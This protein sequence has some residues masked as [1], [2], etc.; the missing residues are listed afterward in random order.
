MILFNTHSHR[1]TKVKIS[2]LSWLLCLLLSLT[3][4]TG[5]AQVVIGQDPP[6]VII[7][8]AQWGMVDKYILAFPAYP[9]NQYAGFIGLRIEAGLD[10][11][12]DHAF[13]ATTA[14]TTAQQ[15][16]VT[17]SSTGGGGL[18]P[19]NFKANLSI[20]QSQP[21][22]WRLLDVSRFFGSNG[23]SN[24]ITVRVSVP[25][26]PT[27][28]GTDP[29]T[30]RIVV[31]C[32]PEYS[33][34]GKNLSVVPTALTPVAGYEQTLSWTNACPLVKN[35]QLQLL[36]RPT[37]VSRTNSQLTSTN[38]GYL[39]TAIP[40]ETEWAQQGTLIET[41]SSNLFYK[42]T[43]AEGEGTYHWRVRALGNQAGGVANPDNWS[44]WSTKDVS[45]SVTAPDA[46]SNWIYSRSFSESGHVAEKLT[47]A[48][49]LQQV[50]QI[51]TRLA[52]P[53][54]STTSLGQQIVATQTLQ[55]FVGRDAVVSLPIP[56]QDANAS[57]LG[58]R[59]A[60]LARTAGVPYEA[61]HFDQTSNTPTDNTAR[62]PLP[63]LEQGYYSS[64][65][66]RVADAEGYPFTRTLF[67]NDGTNR[68][69]EQ[70][71][72]GT[73]LRVRPTETH[74]V[75]TSY[76]S[77]APEEV[78]RLFGREAPQAEGLYKVITTDPNNTS[79]VSYQT[80][81]GKTIATALAGG[82][83]NAALQNLPSAGNTTTVTESITG[84]GQIIS[85]TITL[86]EAVSLTGSY[87]ITPSQ[88]QSTCANYCSTCDYQVLIRIVNVDAEPGSDIILS[89]STIVKASEQCSVGSITLINGG[90]VLSAGTYRIERELVPVDY[91]PVASGVPTVGPSTTTRTL[92]QHLALL[93]DALKTKFAGAAGEP[94]TNISGFLDPATSDVDGL[95]TYLDSKNYGQENHDGQLCYKIPVPGCDEY[96]YFPRLTNY[97]PAPINLT[98]PSFEAQLTDALTALNQQYTK[99]YSAADLLSPFG[100]NA[101]QF[102]QLV[103]NMAA[104][105]KPG[106]STLIYNPSQLQD[107]WQSLLA[108][109]ESLLYQNYG[110]VGN[111]QFNLAKEYLQCAGLNLTTPVSDPTKYDV[112]R[113]FE[114]F[115]YNDQNP[116][117]VNCIRMVGADNTV[118]PPSIPLLSYVLAHFS[119][120]DQAKRNQVYDCLQYVN[121]P[122]TTTGPIPQMTQAEA[123]AQAAMLTQQ[124]QQTCEDRRDEFRRVL[125]MQ[126]H[127]QG[128]YIEGDTY[129]WNPGPGITGPPTISQ[130]LLPSNT[131][132][133]PTCV[134]ESLV[135][136]L[137]E[138][139]QGDAHL[140]AVATND[141]TTN[142]TYYQVGTAA[143][144]ESVK[145]AM[146]SSL[147]VYVNATGSCP[148]NSP[149]PALPW[150]PVTKNS[151]AGAPNGAPS[152]TPH[153]SVTSTG[154][155]ILSAIQTLTAGANRALAQTTPRILVGCTGQLDALNEKQ[156]NLFSLTTILDGW[157]FGKQ[158]VIPGDPGTY[159]T[160]LDARQARPG[161][162]N[163]F[164][165][166]WDYL[167]ITARGD[168][169]NA[170]C[171]PKTTV[172]VNS[173]G[174]DIL[175]DVAETAG[176]HYLIRFVDP[177]SEQPFEKAT[178]RSISAPYIKFFP[179][180]T[181][182]GSL[183]TQSNSFG[184]TVR[185][186]LQDPVTQKLTWTEANVR[187]LNDVTCS[188]CLP[189]YNG[190]N[191]V[192]W[193]QIDTQCI[194][195]TTQA[196]C[197]QWS[198]VPD[199]VIIPP[200]NFPIYDPQ[201]EACNVL[202]ARKLR[203]AYAVEQ[204]RWISSQ[205][206]AFSNQFQQQCVALATQQENFT[207]TYQL[208][209]HHFTLYY[210]DRAGNLLKT[211]PP[212]GVVPLSSA[213]VASCMSTTDRS[214][215]P[216]PNH[217]LSTTYLYNSLHQLEKQNSPDGGETHFFYNRKGQLRFS[218]N[219][220][221]RTA[222]LPSYSYTRY[223]A[224]GRVTEVGETFTDATGNV[225]VPEE[226]KMPQSKAEDM[227]YPPFD[228]VR[229]VT[230]TFYGDLNSSIS[231]L[232]KPQRYLTNRVA[233]SSYDVDGNPAIDDRSYTYYSYDPHGNV[234][235]L[236]QEQP[237]LGRKF[238]RYEYDLISNKVTKV[239]YQENQ[240]D[241]FYHRYDY[242][243]DN[244]LT[245][246][247]TSG[248][249]MI[250]D[251]DARYT[252]FAHGPLKRLEI[253]EDH[254]Q[255]IDY[256][257]TLQGWLKGLN[258]PTN[259]PGQ[260]G[261]T[262][263]LTASAKD[264]F[265][266]ALG[267]F[268]GDYA[269]NNTA[270][271]SGASSLLQPQYNLYNGNIA[272]WTTKTRN[273]LT[274]SG[275]TT[276]TDP[277]VGEQYRYDQLNRITSSKFFRAATAGG[278]MQATDDYAT[279]YT[280]DANGN[281]LT[282]NRNGTSNA[283][284]QL[285]MDALSYSYY[286]GT[287]RLQGI[288]DSAP[289][290]NYYDDIKLDPNTASN[291]TYDNIGNL[292]YETRTYAKGN[293][294]TS[295]D[296]NIYGK[297][298]DSRSGYATHYDYDPQGN[299]IHKDYSLS[300][301][302]DRDRVHHVYYVRD[303][304][305]NVL[306]VYEWDESGSGRYKNS[307]LALTE[308]H[309]YGSSRLGIR[310]LAAGTAPKSAPTEYFQRIVGQ[311]QY[312]LMDHLGNVRA[313]VSDIKRPD[314]AVAG[315]YKPDL[316]AYYGYYPFGQLQPGRNAPANGTLAGGYRYGY[317]GK[318]KDSNG[319]LGLTTYD[320][321]FRIYNPGLGKFLSVDPL[322]RSYPMLTP[323]QF[324]SNRPI[325]MVDL[326]GLEAVG[327][328]P[329]VGPTIVPLPLGTGQSP[330]G[331]YGAWVRN[332]TKVRQNDPHRVQ[333]TDITG[334][335]FDEPLE[336]AAYKTTFGYL[337]SYG[338][339][340]KNTI[341]YTDDP[342]TLSDDYL[343]TV[344]QRSESGEELSAQERSYLNEAYSRHNSRVGITKATITTIAKKFDNFQ[345]D[346]CAAA[347][348]KE[349]KKKGISAEI[350]ELKTAAFNKGGEYI[351]ND[352]VQGTISTNG[353]H[354]G[355]LYEGK[356]YDNIYPEGIEYKD[357]QQ[358]FDA[359]SHKLNFSKRP[360]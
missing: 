189:D 19:S 219:A 74:T 12:P 127:Q 151:N 262:T 326:D 309:I 27:I 283:G 239:L 169:N 39:A 223:D 95:Y 230:S 24:D 339:N 1:L 306:A 63:A 92:A 244:R 175:S 290:Q 310:K 176:H 50:R 272:A 4:S 354:V 155:S 128:Q 188:D 159:A 171:T 180:N 2:H 83:T 299:R 337:Y 336:Y 71:G 278:A 207:I 243:A 112:T 225:A 6:S 241:Q 102:D 271:T 97:C 32:I 227:S 113:A 196:L 316:L 335:L 204:S 198:S 139:C 182:T 304:Q 257:Y 236:C 166:D 246:V 205:V 213:Q 101:G 45:F 126:F 287:N 69:T 122:A 296:W 51:Q 270:W 217:Q 56:L 185:L 9:R 52:T 327:V 308:H 156:S 245:K 202:V 191:V 115:L 26:L 107:C 59:P 99:Q 177:A 96:L 294:G 5:W 250:W 345:C 64:S 356:V 147:N 214:A 21:E 319:E 132:L 186:L 318:E 88:L 134:V 109:L 11:G 348:G 94:W 125:V 322:T 3:A 340:P 14:F 145:R 30:Q 350:V 80:K 235:W 253:G 65:N 285:A 321:G 323:Y 238:V 38:S 226:L 328:A 218:Q 91:Y 300:V 248:D 7:P 194:S 343:A 220:R 93:Q 108:S 20:S 267:Y 302:V 352:R 84:K 342:R 232:G 317:N 47:F 307:I 13:S 66:D 301:D 46:G 114:Q 31:R 110:P 329:M 53:T 8:R 201:P 117:Q 286:P 158:C 269:T 181:P 157:D 234:E 266:M 34:Y 55:D 33:I 209:Y 233:Y 221:Q 37:K 324:A 284:Q 100:Y 44:P 121:N 344:R 77:V 18:T 360:L 173:L 251:Q 255:G 75:R 153:L 252:Y 242:D 81:E 347:I 23:T 29:G 215:W 314:D 254:V 90:I 249:G 178:I 313:L 222:R 210:Y 331:E 85:K 199:G 333:E 341:I 183:L 105:T 259:D 118:S 358:S 203:A 86:T 346:K 98:S 291:Y 312:E 48:N 351:W 179:Q 193:K 135:Q 197:Y 305:G 282:L 25:T 192:Q 131:T 54:Q 41:G 168:N 216:L 40:T 119:T 293:Y 57:S 212:T 195:Q 120:Y 49:G 275:Q 297:I 129:V 111:Y 152:G 149:S 146:F 174:C 231:Y 260:D 123:D 200:A 211:I 359:P 315:T 137:V 276:T 228:E 70:G 277:V 154:R 60:L 320:Y 264:A 138:Q 273:D 82:D 79:S 353:Y 224:L 311:K 184:I 144:L 206:T 141:P 10:S 28:T 288:S 274:S 170:A 164:N 160:L 15:I 133:I 72:V 42:L 281:L 292:I 148:A 298:S 17:V 247:E 325:Q 161:T 76:A 140:S 330:T 43:L 279:S 334:G 268:N 280:Y 240:P 116:A 73:S 190:D 256:T 106:T 263:A 187:G 355:V 124:A 162:S 289:N 61:T 87:S 150:Q 229:Q 62:E 208:G 349:F 67:G 35:Y 89:G 143:E 237:V 58:F 142:T 104:A 165:P 357:W 68:V 332:R 167:L 261:S 163:G 78:I 303:A 136:N 36:F 130:T 258:H 22:H 16:T 338:F 265:G 172:D 103:A 295:V